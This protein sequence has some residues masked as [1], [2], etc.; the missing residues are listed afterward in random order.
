MSEPLTDEEL[1]CIE[2]ALPAGDLDDDSPEGDVRR[3]VAEVRRLRAEAQADAAI[4]GDLK[5]RAIPWRP[6]GESL[7][8]V[9]MPKLERPCPACGGSDVKA[10]VFATLGIEARVDHRDGRSCHIDRR[11]GRA[12]SRP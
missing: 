11:T 4:I 2:A 9:E 7:R 1:A 5:R 3:L 12:V 6:D 10:V 8:G